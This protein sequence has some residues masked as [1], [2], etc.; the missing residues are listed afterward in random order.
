ME[1]KNYSIF[2][3]LYEK[4]GDSIPLESYFEAINLIHAVPASTPQSGD[5]KLSA[6]QKIEDVISNAK[7]PISAKEIAKAAKCSTS[8]VLALLEQYP[9]KTG[10]KKMKLY[11]PGKI[12][13]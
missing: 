10:P 3:S 2:A 5:L 12:N 1:N 6:K 9:F 8:Y 11:Y 4:F 7:E 13:L